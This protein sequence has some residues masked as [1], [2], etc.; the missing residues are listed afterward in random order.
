MVVVMS[1]VA[2]AVIAL[3]VLPAQLAGPVVALNPD[4]GETIGWPDLVDT[5]AGVVRRVPARDHMVILTANYG[6]AGAIDRYGPAHG[7]PRAYS[8]HN[9]YGLWGPPPNTAG[10]VIAVGFR[11]GQAA[12]LLRGCTLA[13]RVDNTA[14]VENHEAGQAV[15]VCAGP[16]QP[17]SA[18]WP[19]IRHLN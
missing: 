17:W 1:A 6:E 18:L 12:S 11:P 2:G 5:V 19:R 13:A 16:Q 4:V 15:L 7:L 8:G 14:G 10:P 3:P 9:A